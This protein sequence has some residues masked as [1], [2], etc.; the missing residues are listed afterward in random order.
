MYCK[1]CGAALPS[2]GF[3]CKSCGAMMDEEQIKMQ[4]KIIDEKEKT[5]IEVNLFSDQYRQDPV[6][7]DYTKRQDNKYLG[8]IIIVLIVIILI[9][10]AILKVM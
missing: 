3:V 10:V 1:K 5:K 6:K 2:H 8:A 7:R 4:K 9:I